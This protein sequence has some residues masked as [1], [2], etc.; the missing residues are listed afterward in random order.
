MNIQTP[1]ISPIDCHGNRTGNPVMSLPVVN[2]SCLQNDGKRI[3][4]NKLKN[5]QMN[6]EASNK[7]L[8]QF[9]RHMLYQG[10]QLLQN[11]EEQI[12]QWKREKLHKK[13]LLYK[14]WMENIYQPI[15][16]SLDW[17][18]MT[19][20]RQDIENWRDQLYEHFLCHTNRRGN[21]FLD[22]DDPTVYQAVTNNPPKSLLLQV[23]TG[24]LKDP[25]NFDERK[26]VQEQSLL[27]QLNTG[28]VPIAHQKHL[29]KRPHACDK[30]S[31]K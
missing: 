8:I 13:K 18:M 29:I 21:V 5:L 11:F 28:H 3:D 10:D 1:I 23:H 25:L 6:A 9:S 27:H 19:N 12:S 14:E 24:R 16:G 22:D 30:S 20:R 2:K 7:H 31:R 15:Q 17:V 26:H 4:E